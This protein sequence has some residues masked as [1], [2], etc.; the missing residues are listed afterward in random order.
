MIAHELA[1]RAGPPAHVH[2]QAVRF[3][4][5]KITSLHVSVSHDHRRLRLCTNPPELAP[6][7]Q[8]EHDRRVH[9]SLAPPASIASLH[10]D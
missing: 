3:D 5:S 6:T 8:H 2:L 7:S 10:Q 4:D 9:D 1:G